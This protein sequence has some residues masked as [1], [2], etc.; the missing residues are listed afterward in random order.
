MSMTPYKG[1]A[2]KP[3]R[4][5]LR[6]EQRKVKPVRTDQRKRHGKGLKVYRKKNK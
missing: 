3:M 1:L 2:R 6:G 4:M 5:Q